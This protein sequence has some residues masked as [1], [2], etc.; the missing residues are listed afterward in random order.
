MINLH[1][2]IEKLVCT[3]LFTE[4]ITVWGG[5]GAEWTFNAIHACELICMTY[6][7]YLNSAFIVRPSTHKSKFQVRSRLTRFFFIRI[8]A[9]IVFAVAEFVAKSQTFA[10][11]AA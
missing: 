2:L 7:S 1:F 4:M 3:F 10:V 9:T 11:I 6:K 5:E 8:V